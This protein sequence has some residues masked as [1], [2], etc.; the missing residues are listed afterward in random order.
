[1]SEKLSIEQL[2]GLLDDESQTVEI[3]PNGDI[4]ATPKS[5]D[6]IERKLKAL[7]YQPVVYY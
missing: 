2:E 4:K 6:E 5:K 1:M 3:L 7:M